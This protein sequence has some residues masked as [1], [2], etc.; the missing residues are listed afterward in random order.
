[1]WSLTEK[2]KTVKVTREIAQEFADM[3]PVPQDRP[4]SE[5]RLAVYRKALKEGLFR[6]V[7][8]GK[9]YCVETDTVYRVNG[10]HT[11][12]LLSSIPVIPEFYATIESF[13]AETLE[14]VA[15]LYSTF[16][17]RSQ[18][19]TATDIY[20]SFAASIPELSQL[21]SRVLSLAVG[22]I[23][24]SKHQDSYNSYPVQ[25][26][27]EILF[28]EVDFVVWL[29][30]YLE[31]GGGHSSNGVRHVSRIG[32]AAAIYLS[33]RKSKRESERF[34]LAVRDETGETP[35]VPD[36]TLAKWLTV[37]SVGVGHGAKKVQSRQAKTREFFVRS[38]HGWNAWREGRTT[39]LK[40]HPGAKIPTLV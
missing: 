20:R 17:S 24:Y 38:I 7:S 8:W 18:L 32:V 3:D 28:D 19:R 25:E 1:M 35:R 33:H 21:P 16:D 9:V 34:W 27:A 12:T 31:G 11:S 23:G 13:R 36:R 39:D 5:R 4:L 37:M 10:K 30:E 22:G 26:R 29:N 6:P 2:P 15:R 14:D 40:Y